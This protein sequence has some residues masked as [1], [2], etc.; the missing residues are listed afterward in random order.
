MLVSFLAFAGAATL[1]VLL[2]GPDTLVVVRSILRGG[3]RQGIL[4]ALGNLV[5]LTIWVTAAAAGIAALLR[6]SEIG[7]SALRIV[8]ACY[9]VYLGIQAWRTRGTTTQT[10][11]K[12]LL[13]SGFKAGILTN[14][15]NPKVGVFFVTF[16]P[17]FVPAGASVGLMTI[18]FGAIFVAITALYWLILLA[19]AGKV[20]AWMNTPKIRR[21]LDVAT[22]GVLVAFG[23]R[24]AT[25]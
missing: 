20:T 22:A 2:P 11:G 4:T 8:G 3:R 13:G 7:Y 19:L 21:R 18:A 6:A 1:I 12:A 5:G 10:E 17:G 9:L 15:L 23:V 16:L 24:L 14:L 25:E